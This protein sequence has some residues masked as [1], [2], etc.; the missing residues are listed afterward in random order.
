MECTGI[1]ATIVRIV[2]EID[3]AR[4]RRRQ[5]NHTQSGQYAGSYGGFHSGGQ[6]EHNVTTID[7]KPQHRDARTCQQHGLT[8]HRA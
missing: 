3:R 1:S 2:Q 5:R 6:Y 7:L 8:T 4:R